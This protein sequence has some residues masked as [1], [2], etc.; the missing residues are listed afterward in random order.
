MRPT[1]R[2]QIS[3]F[4]P[5]F[6]EEREPAWCLRF[7]PWPSAEHTCSRA[8]TDGVAAGKSLEDAKFRRRRMCSM[9]LPCV[10]ATYC[11]PRK[12]ASQP[13]NRRAPTRV[14]AATLVQ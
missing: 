7:L 2:L 11:G 10:G 3:H 13:R 1:A 14:N 8:K 6:F 12:S 5:S 9:R 4:S